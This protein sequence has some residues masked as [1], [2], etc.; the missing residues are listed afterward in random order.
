MSTC[1]LHGTVLGYMLVCLTSH[2]VGKV[3]TFTHTA[4]DGE[5]RLR[6][7]HDLYNIPQ[8]VNHTWWKRKLRNEVVHL[9]A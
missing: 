4:Q 9:W 3:E 7:A 2:E 8:H 6:A 5:L 1:C